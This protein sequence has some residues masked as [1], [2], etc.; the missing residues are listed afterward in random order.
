[1]FKAPI[2]ARLAVRIHRAAEVRGVSVSS[3]IIEAA[4]QRAEEVI[5][6]E[7]VVRLRE[8]EWSKM[9]ELMANP[10]KPTAYARQAAANAALFEIRP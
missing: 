2:P 7:T 4:A 5:E 8:E 3:F 10:P 9:Q 6:R 1:M